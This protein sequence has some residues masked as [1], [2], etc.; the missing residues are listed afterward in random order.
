M[1]CDET[2]DVCCIVLLKD[3]PGD[4]LFKLELPPSPS[5]ARVVGVEFSGT[6]VAELLEVDFEGM[7]EA[8]RDCC[9]VEVDDDN[10]DEPAA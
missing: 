2:V 8:E 10:V 4:A 7:S 3:G 6:A 1:E 9:G 5:V